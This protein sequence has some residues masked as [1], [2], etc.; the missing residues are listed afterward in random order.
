MNA[1]WKL[2]DV[3]ARLLFAE[4]DD[5][6]PTHTRLRRCKN[7][8]SLGRYFVD[9]SELDFDLGGL[10][11]SSWARQW[12]ILVFVIGFYS[13]PRRWGICERIR[14]LFLSVSFHGDATFSHHGVQ[15]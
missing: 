5:L 1:H 10:I 6:G 4:V 3:D 9:R 11:Y 15:G 8:G 14:F 2:I 13:V 7:E 12:I